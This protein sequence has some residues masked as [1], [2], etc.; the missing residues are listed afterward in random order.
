MKVEGRNKKLIRKILIS[1]ETLEL[2]ILLSVIIY[3]KEIIA[4]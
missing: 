3:G 4:K 1:L 2:A